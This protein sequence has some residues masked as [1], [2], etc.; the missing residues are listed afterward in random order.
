MDEDDEKGLKKGASRASVKAP[1]IS[2]EEE[3]LF[4]SFRPCSHAP[5]PETQGL[6]AGGMSRLHHR[7]RALEQLPQLPERLQRMRNGRPSK[8]CGSSL[9][10]NQVDGKGRAANGQLAISSRCRFLSSIS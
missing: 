8:A 3:T 2:S 9:A 7:G 5:A 6:A 10:A 1:I 4:K